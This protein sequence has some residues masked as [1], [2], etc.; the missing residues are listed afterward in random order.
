M[1]RT[2]LM[3]EMYRQHLTLQVPLD[4]KVNAVNVERKVPMVQLV[5]QDL[6][7]RPEQLDLRVQRVQQE[8]AQRVQ[9]VRKDQQEV[10]AHLELQVHEVKQEQSVH[11]K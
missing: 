7:D 10:M 11:L 6:Q 9:L 1:E 8:V 4:R 5:L 2:A 3:Q